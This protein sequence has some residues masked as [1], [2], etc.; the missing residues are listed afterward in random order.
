M[1]KVFVDTSVLFPFSVM[2]VFLALAE[3][4][5][6]EVLWTDELL[7]E[8]ER[9]IVREHHRSPG[10]AA[11]V[12][13]AIR[14][15]FAE[16]RIDPASYTDLVATTPGPDPD[17]H[18]HSAAAVGAAADVLI[19]WDTAGFPTAELGKVGLLVLDP[20]TYLTELLTE[21]RDEVVATVVE[22]ARS[23]TRPPMTV[24]HVLEALEGAGLSTFPR[25]VRARSEE[26]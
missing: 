1:R 19:T 7:A 23:K 9:V 18:V 8:W 3:N 15:C 4:A 10:S 5:I 22:L 20:D 12:T 17:D 2:D 24:E 14:E 11:S 6:H 13:A 26:Q 25:L 16:S 21:L